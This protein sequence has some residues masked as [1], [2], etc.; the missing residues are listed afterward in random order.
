MRCRILSSVYEPD[1]QRLLEILKSARKNRRVTQKAL[2]D[3]LGKPQSFVFKYE[4]GERR[5][6]VA[7]M[8]YIAKL[9]ALD[10]KDLINGIGNKIE[11]LQPDRKYDFRQ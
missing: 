9:L 5:L 4:S 1:Y 10:T 2:A 3:A 11:P 8:I 7:E 6:D